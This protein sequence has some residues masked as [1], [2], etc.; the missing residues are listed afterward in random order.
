MRLDTGPGTQS[1]DQDVY[2][3]PQDS[4]VP[5]VTVEQQHLAEPGVHQPLHELD[6][7]C[8]GG[9]RRQGHGPRKESAVAL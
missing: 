4:G 1:G 3:V 7:R 9:L 6:K 5:Q 2:G 8:L